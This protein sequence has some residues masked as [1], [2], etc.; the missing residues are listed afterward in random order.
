MEDINELSQEDINE[1]SKNR[2]VALDTSIRILLGED[3]FSVHK[4][5]EFEEILAEAILVIRGEEDKIPFPDWYL[6][7]GP[8]D[9][10]SLHEVGSQESTIVDFPLFAEWAVKDGH[11]PKIPESVIETLRVIGHVFSEDYQKAVLLK[12][13]DD[14]IA[15]WK[16][17]EAKSVSEKD[18][19]EK[20]I[21]KL[22]Q[23]RL[24][25]EKLY[26]KSPNSRQAREIRNESIVKLWDE[27]KKR[28]PMLK[29]REVAEELFEKLSFE[30]KMGITKPA[31]ITRLVN[32][33]KEKQGQPARARGRS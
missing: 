1:L 25:A 19:Q 31:S 18:T 12:G 24:D 21:T 17:L 14:K 26:R 4:R 5:D 20:A 13:I 33:S 8:R 22:Q 27:I 6:G 2:Q 30:L 3:G 16:S 11:L 7:V 29:D 32:I 10:Y 23:N 9:S 15:E 28:D